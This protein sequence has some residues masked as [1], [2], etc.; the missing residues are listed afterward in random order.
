MNKQVFILVC[1]GLLVAGC[2]AFTVAERFVP[3]VYTGEAAG[4]NG[5]I[6]VE[7]EVDKS[8]IL[9]IRI[10][11]QNEDDLF[12]GEAMDEL[13]RRV[14]ET[15]DTDIDAVSGAT[16]TSDA[17]LRAINEALNKAGLRR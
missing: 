15:D 13:R 12:G 6:I 9:D 2:G 14:L 5:P 16:I 17:F 11:K 10:E 7:V 4:Y 8:A 3:G 1:A